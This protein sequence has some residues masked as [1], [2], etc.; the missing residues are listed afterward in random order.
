MNF[1]KKYKQNKAR[2]EFLKKH[3]RQIPGDLAT[4]IYNIL[5]EYAGYYDCE[6]NLSQFIYHQGE[7]P[8]KY[9]EFGGC[10]EYRFQGKLGFGGKFWNCN[11]RF[12]VNGYSEDK[13]PKEEKI[14]TEVNELLKPIYKEHISRK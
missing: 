13:G 14:I 12:Y 9:N 2:K 11:S 8:S 7:N 1:Y 5:V 3:N 4:E 6:S 10:T